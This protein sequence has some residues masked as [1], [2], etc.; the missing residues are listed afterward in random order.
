[1]SRVVV[2]VGASS[3]I[4]RA[5]A[6]LLAGTREHLALV[7][8]DEQALASTAA[9]CTRAGASSVSTHP[10]DIRDYDA[11]AAAMASVRAEHGRIDA[12]VNSAG[13]V[14][15]GRFDEVPTEVWDGVLRTNVL[16]TANVCRAVLPDMRARN[17]GVIV[18][19]GSVL[20]EIAVPTMSAYVVSKWAVRA[21][22]RE[23]QLD[24]R[25]RPGVQISIVSPGGVDTPIYGLAANYLGVEGRPPPPVY[26]P[27][28]V[29]QS[30]VEQIDRP[31]KRVSVGFANPLMRLG[32]GLTPGLFDVVVGPLFARVA[33]ARD[34]VP[35]RTGN[36]LNAVPSEATERGGHGWGLAV[37][38]R[39]L[40][41]DVAGV[42]VNLLERKPERTRQPVDGPVDDPADGP[43]DR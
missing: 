11:V 7:A 34:P 35:E 24:N 42:L 23:L 26:S 29:A 31:S 1:M 6:L 17:D 28:R 37:I 15:Y 39:D 16:G 4:G 2:V 9:D 36:V 13:V 38:A 12:L 3:G 43:A 27:Q 21:L 33:N 41:G 18:L 5:A 14:A 40:T 32:F 20:G 30:V 8:R 22:A 19:L 10:V 25:D